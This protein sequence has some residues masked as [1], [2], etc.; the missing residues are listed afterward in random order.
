MMVVSIGEREGSQAWHPNA[1]WSCLIRP[2]TDS[3][4]C[5]LSR[6][7]PCPTAGGCL[8]IWHCHAAQRRWVDQSIVRL[9]HHG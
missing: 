9:H 6:R 5:C 8:S 7:R 2:F 4:Y 3:R 1:R